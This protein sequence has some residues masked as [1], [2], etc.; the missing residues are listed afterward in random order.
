MTIMELTEYVPR[1]DLE[2]RWARV[3]R[4]MDCDALVVLQNVDQ[5]YL[6]GT[7][8][9]GVLWFPREGE[10]LLAVR[11]SYERAKAESAV[12]NIVPLNKYSELPE[13]IRNPGETIGFELDVL[14]VATYQQV[15]KYFS[16]SKIVD[17]ST[18]VRSARAVKSAYEI[19]CIR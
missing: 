1:E 5:F 19:E 2:R 17:G 3:R 13:L 8:Q 18:A 16:K 7:L 6:T 9:T 11:K 4:F 12:K 14:P 15:S 10:P